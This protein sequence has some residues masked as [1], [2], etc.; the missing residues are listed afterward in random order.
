MVKCKPLPVPVVTSRAVQEAPKAECIKGEQMLQ[1]VFREPSIRLLLPYANAQQ[2]WRDGKKPT[3]T[4][5]MYQGPVS[6]GCGL[7]WAV[8]ARFSRAALGFDVNAMRHKASSC[9]AC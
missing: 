1:Q 2:P 7:G 4:Q 5:W 9:H 8:E 3:S 6:V